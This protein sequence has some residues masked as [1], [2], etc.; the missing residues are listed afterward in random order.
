MLFNL[1][2]HCIG[3]KKIRKILLQISQTKSVLLSNWISL[4][5]MRNQDLKPW[6]TLTYRV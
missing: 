3:Q 5:R 4:A 1:I 6:S 2:R